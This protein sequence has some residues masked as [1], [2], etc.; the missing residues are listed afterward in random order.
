MLF[1][2]RGFTAIAVLVLALG[3]GVNSAAF[4]LVNALVLRPIA[5]YNPQELVSCYSKDTK[6]PGSYRAFSYPNY[7]DIRDRNTAFASLAAHNLAMVGIGDGETTRRMFADIVTC[8][9]FSTFGM[10]VAKGREFLAA[11]ERPGSMIRVTIVSYSY[12]TRTGADPDLVGK[13]VRING[14]PYTVVGIAPAGFTGSMAIVAPDFWLPLGVHDAVLNDFDSQR[15]PLNDRENHCLFLIGR[16]RPGL[17]PAAVDTQLAVLARQM[18]A[19]FPVANKD[20]TLL[21]RPLDRLSVST[22]PNENNEVAGLSVMLMFTAALVLLI[23]CLNLA[24][25]MLARGTARRREFAIRFALGGG[26]RRILRQLFTESL[27]LSIMGGFAGLVFAQWATNLLISSMARLIPLSIEFHA[28]ADPRVLAATMGFCVLSVVVFSIGPAWKLSRPDVAVDLKEQA[29]QDARGGNR[30]LMFGRRNFLVVGQIAISLALM[31]AAGLFIRG[32]YKAARVDLGFSLDHGVIV[33]VDPSL[34]GYDEVRGRAL[35]G[36]LLERLQRVPGV[37]AASIAA[38]VP[39]GMISLGCTVL[40]SGAKDW[41]QGGATPSGSYGFDAGERPSTDDRVGADLNIIG[42]DYFKVLGLRFLQGRPFTR[43]EAE[44]ESAS[45]VVIIDT[46][47]AKKLWPEG[48][49]LG[50][51]IRLLSGG[52]QTDAEIVGIV[53]TIRGDLFGPSANPHLYMPFGS[54]YQSNMNIHLRISGRGAATEAALLQTIRSEIRQVDDRLPLLS[55]RTF[56]GHVDE[57]LSLWLVRSGARVFSVFGALALFLAVVGVY[58]LKAYTV[59]RRTRE[60]GIRIALGATSRSAL[61]LVL[62][63]GLAMTFAGVGIGLLLAIMLGKL[64]SGM[65][66]EVSGTDPLILFAAP[67][68]LSAASL[69]A[70]YLPARRAAR[71]DPLA[72]LRQE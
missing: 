51:H 71:V 26:R 2:N 72:A 17:S 30:Y 61:L 10:H 35:Y 28:G 53:P 24:N 34:G 5:A 44:S 31:V 27:M 18:G 43:A 65:L 3:I 60:I 67:A 4:S 12:W 25:M 8:N 52:R 70:C 62:R 48:N 32:A 6:R 33:D 23:A 11:E 37:E 13:S 14:Q 45:G 49:A 9:Y 39:L 59:A 50:Q 16:I 46:V 15:R 54:R 7:C 68:A 64:L 22:S 57:S 66:Y 1:K 38:T 47:L 21:A 40:R 41:N 36:R 69:A 58:G 29:G 42:A 55:L 56:Y 19:A 20:Q 63:E